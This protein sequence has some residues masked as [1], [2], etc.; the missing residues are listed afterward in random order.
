M[1]LETLTKKDNPDADAV[2]VLSM[3]LKR[4]TPELDKTTPKQKPANACDDA[5]DMWDNVP[6]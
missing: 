5:E 4:M 6:I 1:S 2:T 3:K